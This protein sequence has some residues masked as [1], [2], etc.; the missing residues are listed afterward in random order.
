MVASMVIA[1]YMTIEIHHSVSTLY[2]GGSASVVVE[3]GS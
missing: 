1:H 2:E 3:K